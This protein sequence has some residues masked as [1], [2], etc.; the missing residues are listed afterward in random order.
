MSEEIA[1]WNR[2][3]L[4]EWDIVG[5][6]HFHVLGE[7]FIFVAMTKD[8]HCIKEE[9]KEDEYLWNRLYWKAVA[10]KKGEKP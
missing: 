1:P 3:L 9:G 10:I 5:M 8:G 6:N 7:R 4:K 2:S